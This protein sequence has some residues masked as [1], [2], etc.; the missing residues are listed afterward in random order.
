MRSEDFNTPQREDLIGFN[1]IPS[2]WV[3]GAVR[4]EGPFPG[5]FRILVS[6]IDVDTLKP[7]LP[8][9]KAREDSKQVVA[10]FK[11][12]DE[13]VFNAVCGE[14]QKAGWTVHIFKYGSYSSVRFMTSHK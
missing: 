4:R 13:S 5:R 8:G 11:V 9:L 10:Y 1:S 14:L 7:T 12:G 3:D 6:G 2:M